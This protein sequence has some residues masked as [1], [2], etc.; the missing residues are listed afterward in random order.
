[1]ASAGGDGETP[2]TGGEEPPPPDPPTEGQG[3]GSELGPVDEAGPADPPIPGGPDQLQ[4][5]FGEHLDELRARLIFSLIGLFGTFLVCFHFS[6]PLMSFVLDPMID[7]LSELGYTPQVVFTRAQEKFIAYLKLSAVAA[8]FVSSPLLLYQ[9]WAFV[10]AGLYDSERRYVLTFAPT[11]LLSFVSGVLFFYFLMM[12]FGLKFLLAFGGDAAITP[13]IQVSEHISFFLTLSL[14]TGLIFELP[15]VMLFATKIGVVSWEQFAEKRRFA[16][17]FGF[18]LAA[19]LTPPD[20]F[21]QIMLALPFCFLYEIGILVS[22]VGMIREGE[23]EKRINLRGLL[24]LLLPTFLI[25]GMVTVKVTRFPSS[26]YKGAGQFLNPETYREAISE[27]DDVPVALWV[28]ELQSA[29]GPTRLAG[30]RQLSGSQS[31]EKVPKLRHHMRYDVD[32]AVQGVAACYLY[33][34]DRKYQ[35]EAGLRL[36]ELLETAPRPRYA[37]LA[38]L[39]LQRVSAKAHQLPPEPGEEAVKKAAVFWRAW[40]KEK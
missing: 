14:I 30:L 39:Q 16:I 7:T 22:R 20:V 10:A 40:L 24:L 32:P 1:M 13:M 34:V 15:L 8:V 21:T 31:T 11:S 25:A 5:S 12:P 26:Q 4:L 3:P 27:F 29:D 36:I 37:F 19:I 33:R 17:L 18:I 23:D 35:R 38:H 2:S 9:A 6:E 28:Q